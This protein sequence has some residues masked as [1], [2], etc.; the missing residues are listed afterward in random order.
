MA[1]DPCRPVETTP[2]LAAPQLAPADRPLLIPTRLGNIVALTLTLW[3]FVMLL[4]A[5]F[6]S[7]V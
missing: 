1:I 5:V 2:D 3:G 7:L 4:Y 6:R